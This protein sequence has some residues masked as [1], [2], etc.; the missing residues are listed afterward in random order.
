M[1]IMLQTEIRIRAS[2]G[3]SVIVCGRAPLHLNHIVK[4]HMKGNDVCRSLYHCNLLYS[5][6]F[7][8]LEIKNTFVSKRTK[9]KYTYRAPFNTTCE[10]Y[11]NKYLSRTETGDPNPADN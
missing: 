11:V 7:K 10:E 6:I 8:H 1:A 5:G 2:S 4:K 9:Y 3:A